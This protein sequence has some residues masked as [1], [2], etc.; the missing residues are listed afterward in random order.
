MCGVAELSPVN[1]RDACELPTFGGHG[2]LSAEM[3]DFISPQ[4]EQD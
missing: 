4:V 1:N 2:L 3:D